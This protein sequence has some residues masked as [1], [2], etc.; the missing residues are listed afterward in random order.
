MTYEL[1]YDWSS[2]VEMKWFDLSNRTRRGTW[3]CWFTFF[4]DEYD[5]SDGQHWIDL[6]VETNKKWDS[7]LIDHYS[8]YEELENY[9]WT[10]VQFLLAT[11]TPIYAGE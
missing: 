1:I 5:T 4:L 3:Q 2:P 9:L 6:R 10:I 8:S 11:S 7:H